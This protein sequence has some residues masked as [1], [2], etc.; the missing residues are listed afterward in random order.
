MLHRSFRVVL[1]NFLGKKIMVK[2]VQCIFNSFV[3]DLHPLAKSQLKGWMLQMPVMVFQYIQKM[4]QVGCIEC[5]VCK[6]HE[7]D[8]IA[9]T[10]V[11]D[12]I[13]GRVVHAAKQPVTGVKNAFPVAPGKDCSEQPGNFNILEF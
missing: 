13:I 10:E 9:F 11:H 12:K 7:W 4:V 1:C 8:Q 5:T 2:S 6:F 3:A